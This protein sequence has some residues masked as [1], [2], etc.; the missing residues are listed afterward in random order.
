[1]N[2]VQI[3]A[4]LWIF[5]MDFIS[6]NWMMC[7]KILST[8]ITI[9]GDHLIVFLHI[10]RCVIYFMPLNINKFPVFNYLQISTTCSQRHLTKRVC[11]ATSTVATSQPEGRHFGFAL[12]FGSVLC[13]SRSALC[14]DLFGV[15]VGVVVV[16][17]L[18]Q[19]H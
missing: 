8:L 14:C 1:M 11:V 2:H 17:A 6:F 4:W 13:L 12:L 5:R 15:V 9:L 18:S 7:S 3:M 19:F 10:L 16:G